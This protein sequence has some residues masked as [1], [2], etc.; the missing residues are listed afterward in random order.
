MNLFE[1]DT[2]IQGDGR[3]EIVSDCPWVWEWTSPNDMGRSDG[4]K[5]H[6]ALEAWERM[7]YGG[8]HGRAVWDMVPFIS[9]TFKSGHVHTEYLAYAAR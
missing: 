3:G 1:L 6:F 5:D 7:T 8:V 4:N 2:L 9:T